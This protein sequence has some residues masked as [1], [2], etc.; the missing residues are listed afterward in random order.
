MHSSQTHHTTKQTEQKGKRAE[1]RWRQ[2]ELESGYFSTCL[3]HQTEYERS[4]EVENRQKRSNIEQQISNYT[5]GNKSKSCC[6]KKKNNMTKCPWSAFFPLKQNLEVSPHDAKEQYKKRKKRENN[7]IKYYTYSCKGK[8]AY[9]E[10]PSF[11]EF[12][13]PPNWLFF[14]F[15]FSQKLNQCFHLFPSKWYLWQTI[16]KSASSSSV[17]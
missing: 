17:S 8:Q 9:H 4:R 5:I 14:P 1:N 16:L 11:K 15:F 7:H 10:K 2:A 3:A 6:K 13:A 12:W